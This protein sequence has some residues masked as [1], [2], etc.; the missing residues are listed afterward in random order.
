MRELAE[1]ENRYENMKKKD[2]KGAEVFKKE[3]SLRFQKT[4]FSFIFSIIYIFVNRFLKFISRSN[5]IRLSIVKSTFS[6]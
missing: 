2:P 4:V 1:L 3:M 5:I 6:C